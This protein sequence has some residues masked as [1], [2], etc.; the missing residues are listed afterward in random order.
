MKKDFVLLFSFFA[1]SLML[2]F[3]FVRADA[4]L[5][6]LVFI[7]DAGHGGVDPGSVIDGIYE[8]DINL[9]IS[10]ALKNKLI[11]LGAKVY[12]TRE[13]DYDLSAPKAYRRK[14]SDFDHR[15]SMI[16]D[17][18][19]NYY[20]SIHLNF[21]DDSKYFGPQVFYSDV[22]SDNK[23]IAKSIQSFM[24]QYLNTDREIKR[25]S[26]NLYMYKK[27]KV[28]GVLIECGFLSNPRERKKLMQ[29]EYIDELAWVIAK[30]FI[31]L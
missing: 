5:Y 14:K 23:Q 22:L 1:F 25:V 18:K 2:F 31:S 19:A 26:S 3:P 29:D 16:N 12:L 24:N 7:I 6:N 21:L 28:P 10:R 30:S 13:G 17:S 4:P 27:L 8:K 9:R 15:I 20:I 11:D